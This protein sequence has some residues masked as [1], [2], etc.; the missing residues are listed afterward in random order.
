MYSIII[1][2]DHPITLNGIETY[3]K[4]RNYNVLGAYDSGL[5]A[6]N[7]IKA[8]KPDFA[9]LD[10]SMPDYSGIEVLEEV[11][12][13][14]TTTKI[15]LYTMYKEKALFDKAISLGANGYL[16]KEFAIEEL[17]FCLN[18]LKDN[19][20]WISP[21]LIDYLNKSTNHSITNEIVS[22]LTPAERKIATLIAEEKNSKQIADLLFISE[23][24]V[25]NHRSKIIKK[26]GLPPSKNALL[27]W[28]TKNVNKIRFNSI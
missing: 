4:K 24:T 5:G 7:N 16:L 14:N 13:V 20:T 3:L 1:A 17:E 23:K 18:Q 11:R 22:K 9:L 19:K 27:L 2:D 15:I 21:K 28:A 26:L 25:E 10:L 8:L 6:L 12:K